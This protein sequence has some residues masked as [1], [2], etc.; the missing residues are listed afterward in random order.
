MANLFLYTPL[1]KVHQN[2]N[3]ACTKSNEVSYKSDFGWE[4]E[5]SHSLKADL[6]TDFVKWNLKH[7]NIITLKH[8]HPFVD[9]GSAQKKGHITQEEFE[10]LSME[11]NQGAALFMCWISI[12]QP[13]KNSAALCLHQ[14]IYFSDIQKERNI[15]PD[16]TI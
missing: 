13:Q 14:N 8:I 12:H 9:Q 5:R 3:I 16:H 11:I 2:T 4:Y 10:R 7:T 15:C 6:V 1:P